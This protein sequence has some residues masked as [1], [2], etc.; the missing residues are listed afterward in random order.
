MLGGDL[1]YLMYTSGSTGVPKGV[2]IT[3]ANLAN[4][5][6]SVPGQI[7][8]G[9]FGRRYALLQG[10]GTDFGN[11]VLFTSLATGGILHVLDFDTATSPGAVRV[12]LHACDIDYV[13]IVPSHLAALA[14]PHGL[15][16]LLPNKTLVL[17]GEA[18]TR[19]W[20]SDLVEIA[21]DRAVINHYGP[22]ETTI[23][24][25]TIPLTPGQLASG[26]V[27]IGRPIGNTRLFVLDGHLGPV[28]PAVLG[29]LVRRR[30]G[31]G[32]WVRGPGWPDG[33]AVRRV[34]VRPG[35]RAH[36]PHR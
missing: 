16:G 2:Q 18:A 21:G 5:A 9:E 17:G 3:H 12:Y 6:T 13:K 28:P 24:V 25:V 27:P 34:P 19:D 30:R 20:L 7:G 23:G 36:V 26:R 15:A 11:T 35:G 29:E 4:Y 8:L 10:L 1:A 33:R 14:D 22:T 32:P 31:P